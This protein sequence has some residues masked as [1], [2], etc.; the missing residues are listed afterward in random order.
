MKKALFSFVATIAVFTFLTSTAHAD[1]EFYT[2]DAPGSTTQK[3]SFNFNEQPYLYV[4][5]PFVPQ[6]K[7]INS[8]W[9][10][11]NSSVSFAG[12]GPNGTGEN[13]LTPAS[14]SPQVGEWTVNGNAFYAD[15]T[16]F[17]GQTHFTVTPEPTSMALFLTG[18]LALGVARRRKKK[19][20]LVS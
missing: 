13:W 12:I 9:I 8:F 16:S 19:K 2:V 11:P 5:V 17:T 10:A 18:G 1:F 3:T 15:G 4:M 7:I 20:T 14:W 6:Q